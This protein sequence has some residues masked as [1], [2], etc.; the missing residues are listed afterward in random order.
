MVIKKLLGAVAVVGSLAAGGIAGMV[1][2]PDLA[3]A[4]NASG[5]TTVTTNPDTGGPPA[6][7]GFGG[8]PRGDHHG[9]PFP[10]GAP[11]M[12]A[13]PGTAGPN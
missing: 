5:T 9:P 2:V 8:G 4:H 1:L 7:P 10:G 3:G 11:P 6:G 12:G 13:G